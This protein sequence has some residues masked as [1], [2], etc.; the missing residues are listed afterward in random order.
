MMNKKIIEIFE[1]RGWGLYEHSNSLSEMIFTGYE[2]I[3]LEAGIQYVPLPLTNNPRNPEVVFENLQRRVQQYKDDDSLL[4]RLPYFIDLETTDDEELRVRGVYLIDSVVY[5]VG[6]IS[7]VIDPRFRE[8][9]DI[10]TKEVYD[11]KNPNIIINEQ[12]MGTLEKQ[13][14]KATR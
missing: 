12:E 4:N 8:M 2:N 14:M 3:R 13:I 7:L 11:M 6:Q 10:Y 9:S 5:E 1:R